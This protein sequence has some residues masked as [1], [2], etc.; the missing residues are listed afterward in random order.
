MPTTLALKRDSG[1]ADRLRQ[2]RVIL[3]G[4]EIGRIGNGEEK[5][6]D[7]SSGQHQL[8]IKVDWGRSNAVSLVAVDGQSAL[9]NCGSNLRGMRLLLAIYYATF[10]FRNY[11]WLRAA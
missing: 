5:H 11:L 8:M 1:F 3:D 6:F 10:G 4:L 7:I 9:F 2:Y